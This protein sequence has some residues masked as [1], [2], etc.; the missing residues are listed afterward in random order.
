MRFRRTSKPTHPNKAYKIYDKNHSNLTECKIDDKDYLYW[1]NK[2]QST[3]C[4]SALAEWLISD[5]FINYLITITFEPNVVKI[6]KSDIQKYLNSF[7]FKIDRKLKS[8]LNCQISRL[9][10]FPEDSF[11]KTNNGEY[12]VPHIHAVLQIPVKY[13]D[14][15]ISKCT[16]GEFTVDTRLGY[17][18]SK[19]LLLTLFNDTASIL[20]Y[21]D[22]TAFISETSDDTHRWIG[23][24]VKNIDKNLSTFSYEDI[25]IIQN[26][27]KPQKKTN[28]NRPAPAG[29]YS[30]AQQEMPNNFI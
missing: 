1:K 18:N 12:S 3:N 21:N 14:K 28:N 16:T 26:T 30:P 8:N 10:A 17:K 20:T 27:I 29:C 15:F 9:F 7:V 2:R 11:N 24:D 13:H 19:K 6:D 5:D 4:V 23:Y 22:C 25:L